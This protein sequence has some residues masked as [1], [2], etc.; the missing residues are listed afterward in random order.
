MSQGT[1]A[2]KSLSPRRVFAAL[3]AGSVKRA[4]NVKR[5][6]EA[7]RSLK[8]LASPSFAGSKLR[9]KSSQTG[10][11]YYTTIK[12]ELSALQDVPVSLYGQLVG[13]GGM[14]ALGY[15]LA[16]KEE[17]EKEESRSEQVKVEVS[18]EDVEVDIFRDTLLRYVGYSNELGEA[19]RPI[20]GASAANLTYI[21]A[22][23]Y[24]VADAL[25]KGYK[26]QKRSLK[27]RATSIFT[28]LDTG[29]EGYLTLAEV[30]TAFRDLRIPL[31]REQ[32]EDFFEKADVK[33][34]N[35]IDFD[36]FLL[37][38]ERADSELAM[39]I[40]AGSEADEGKFAWGKQGLLSPLSVIST[41]DALVWQLLASVALP[42]F[43]INRV[44]T[45]L[46]IVCATLPGPLAYTPTVVGLLLIPAIITPLDVL[47]DVLMDA[48]MRPVIFGILDENRDG[49]LSLSEMKEKLML[50]PDFN[51]SEAQLEALFEEMDTDQ[52]GEVSIAEWTAVG[53]ELYQEAIKQEQRRV[54]GREGV[55]K[56]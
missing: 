20:V 28:K 45:F 51:L 46:D 10:G 19:F 48:T 6:P 24:V 27:A 25:D 29:G 30:R 11:R 21:A 18:D 16:W 37:A 5:M 44:V 2:A 36:E 35:R 15:G 23:G 43:T 13:V 33:K 54:R 52:N 42:G 31:S 14:V 12:S 32:V 26:A 47:A 7:T 50:R 9:Q 40:D 22:V 53:F 41:V 4:Q 1:K 3:R 55:G 34:N 56:A 8:S 49:T 39:L 38:L 17:S